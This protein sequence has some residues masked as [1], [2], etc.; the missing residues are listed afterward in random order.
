MLKTCSAFTKIQLLLSFQIILRLNGY[1][2]I[3][4]TSF[5]KTSLL[6]INQVFFFFPLAAAL[7][8]DLATNSSIRRSRSCFT[9]R[10]L[11]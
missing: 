7:I 11:N 5:L 10:F 1:W 6:I 3:A 9:F 8:S 4:H 2:L